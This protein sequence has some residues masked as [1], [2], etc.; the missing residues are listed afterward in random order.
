VL[1]PEKKTYERFEF[2]VET[3]REPGTFIVCKLFIRVDNALGVV[4]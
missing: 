3:A 1:K 4:Q 2:G